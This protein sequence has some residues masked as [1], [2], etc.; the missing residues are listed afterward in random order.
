MPSPECD[1]N[2]EV[3]WAEAHRTT[4]DE[5]GP[6]CRYH[7]VAHHRRGWKLKRIRPG[8]YQ[9]TSPLGQVFTVRKSL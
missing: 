3:P 7:H 2:H 4:I 1:L 5:L 9:W 6:L 8:V